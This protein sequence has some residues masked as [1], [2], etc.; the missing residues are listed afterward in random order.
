[1]SLDLTQ[2]RALAAAALKVAVDKPWRDATIFDLAA[3]AAAPI[4]DFAGATLGDAIDAV[5]ES[6]D[7]EAAKGLR[8]VDWTVRVRD[9]L[10]DV[11]MRRFEAMERVRGGVRAIEITMERDP[12]A[13]AHQH[14]RAVRSARWLLTLAGLDADGVG[15]AARAQG[16]A[17]ILTQAR[18]AWR[19]D[20]AG[21]FVKTMAALDKALRQAEQTF[22][23][24]GGFEP[25]SAAGSAPADP[26]AA[27]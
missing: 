14:I 22:G 7:A 21:D 8:A 3:A 2:R 10:F 17:L 4:E 6:F 12:A 23:R 27:A 13:L 15:G 16:F 20:D 26:P 1:M 11:A 9:R 18:A 25:Q 19:L 5:E 24:Y